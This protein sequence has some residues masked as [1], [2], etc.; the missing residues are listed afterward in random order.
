MA[1]PGLMSSVTISTWAPL[2]ARKSAADMPP[3]S[4]MVSYTSTFLPGATVPSRMS[5]LLTTRPSAAPQCS[6][7]SR[8]G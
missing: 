5:Q 1:M 4:Q 6:F 2:S 3:N 7:C 8:N